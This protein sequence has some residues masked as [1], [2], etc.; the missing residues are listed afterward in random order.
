MA[1]PMLTG[2]G[3][4]PRERDGGIVGGKVKMV[5]TPHEKVVSS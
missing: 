1:M 5:E 4:S 3:I 2:V